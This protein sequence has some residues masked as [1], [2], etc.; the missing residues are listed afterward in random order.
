MAV[1]T[2]EQESTTMKDGFQSAFGGIWNV[3]LYLLELI[4]SL[5]GLGGTTE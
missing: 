4:L 2:T 5:I 1:V 3:I